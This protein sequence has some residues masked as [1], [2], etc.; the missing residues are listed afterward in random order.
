MTAPLIQLENVTKR[1]GE[2]TILDAFSISIQ[3]GET[4]TII[5]KSGVGKSV[6][7]KH[8][9]GLL[10]PDDGEI[11]FGGHNLKE[12]N[13]TERKSLKSQ[14]SYMFQNNALFDSMT[15]FD[16][17]ALPLVER[18][19]FSRTEI[20]RRARLMIDRLELNEV[21]HQYPSQLSGG[22]QKRVA[23]ARALIVRP[24]IILFDEPTT[25]LDPIRKNAVLGMI[26]HYKKQFG[27][28]AIIVSHD[29]PDIFFISDRI[30]IIYEGKA[31]FQGSP[32]E[33]ERFDHPYTQEFVNSLVS[34]KDEMTGL[35]TKR[36]FERQYELEFG[37]VQSL[38]ESTVI[39]LSM[40]NPGKWDGETEEAVVQE[41]IPSLA[42]LVDKH[43]GG[44]GISSRYGRKEILSVLPHSD[45]KR[46]DTFLEE[47]A[48]E[49][50]G[51]QTTWRQ[52]LP[53]V[54]I[55]FSIN[56]GATHSEPGMGLDTLVE[57]AKS[58]Q[59]SLLEVFWD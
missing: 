28:T 25:G 20:E 7:L 37:L 22:M 39:L 59:T 40:D 47:L 43:I 58:Q 45:E 4:T 30:A 52:N 49:L 34:L 3:E 32:S 21:P 11:R 1:F 36:S 16:N 38:E 15:V 50:Q 17:I 5:G 57:Q 26:A 29:I 55:R 24:K 12:M 23:L 44:V 14:F 41:I 8:M 19:T 48:I 46:A 35:E 27:F 31:I 51:K 10:E 18:S 9:I 56:A 42:S 53:D 2:R 54:K 6:T 33:L 13:R